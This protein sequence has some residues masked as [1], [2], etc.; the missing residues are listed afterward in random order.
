[1]FLKEISILGAL[2]RINRKYVPAYSKNKRKSYMRLSK[3]WTEKFS[4]MI[5]QI[6]VQKGEFY[7]KEKIDLYITQTV[8]PRTD[9]DAIL[10]GVF[11]ALEKGKVIKNDN[12]ILDFLVSRKKYNGTEELI[13]QIAEAGTLL[14]SIRGEHEKKKTIQH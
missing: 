11:D 4:S 2:P 7:T 12:Q 9:S 14:E 6:N 8:N 10:K 3:E 5:L 1:M 13:I